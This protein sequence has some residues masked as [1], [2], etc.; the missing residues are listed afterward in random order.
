MPKRAIPS[1]TDIKTRSARLPGHIDTWLEQKVLAGD[2]P[3]INQAIVGELSKIKQIE[4]E[5]R[6]REIV[7]QQAKEDI[8]T[9]PM[10]ETINEQ[11]EKFRKDVLDKLQRRRDTELACNKE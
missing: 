7:L 4:E 8:E 3:N 10:F 6:Q 9:D 1:R 2:Y 5:R 11:F